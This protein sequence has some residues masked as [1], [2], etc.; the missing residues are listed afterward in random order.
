MKEMF[1]LMIHSTHFCLQLYG[2]GY[3][4]K[5]HSDSQTQ[6]HRY[7]RYSFQLTARVLIYEPS[8]RQ[9]ITYHSLCYRSCEARAGTKNSLMGPLWGIDL[10]TN[11]TMS[12]SSTMEL[13]LTP[14]MNECMVEF[15]K[16]TNGQ[17][18]NILT[19]NRLGIFLYFWGCTFVSAHQTPAVFQTLCHSL[20]L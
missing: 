13:H 12:G 2:V 17:I 1:Y 3:M 6:C 19:W 9:D 10:T 11:C 4:V 16:C 18:L 5:N 7:R 8:H 14:W 20:N 15:N